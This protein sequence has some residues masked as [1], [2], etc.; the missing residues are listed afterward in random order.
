VDVSTF[1]AREA[2]HRKHATPGE[3]PAAFYDRTVLGGGALAQVYSLL[4]SPLEAAAFAESR[5]LRR[6]PAAL[7]LHITGRRISET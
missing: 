4:R 7:G 1:L 3:H 2:I 6:C 5:L